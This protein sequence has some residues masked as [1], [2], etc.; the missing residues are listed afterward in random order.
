MAFVMIIDDNEG[1]CRLM[2]KLM[3]FRGH[4]TLTFLSPIEALQYMEESANRAPHLIIID[5]DMPLMDGLTGL[6]HLRASERGADIPIAM[7]TA[8]DDPGLIH[9]A[10][11]AG[12]D[13]FWV[14]STMDFSA[15]NREVD[16]L[17][18]Q[19]CACNAELNETCTC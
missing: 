2:A 8:N 17:L 16:L 7:L 11:N 5:Y 15:I 13:A 6:R 9:A 1:Q 12:A 3:K 19:G 18:K 14:K 4:S 10:L